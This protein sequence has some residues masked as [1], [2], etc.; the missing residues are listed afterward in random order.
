[1]DKLIRSTVLVGLFLLLSFASKAQGISVSYLIPTDGYL[2]APVSPFSVR[3][4]RLPF[5]RFMGLQGGATLYNFPG[6]PIDDM[7]FEYNEPM[8]GSTFGVIVPAELYVG[9]KFGKV[10]VIASG[11]VFGLFFF[12]DRMIEGNWDRGYADFRGWEVANGNVS[13][14]NK[15][16]YGWLG[17]LEFEV[18]VTRQYS[19]TFGAHYLYGSAASSIS[20]EVTGGTTANGLVTEAIGYL[21]ASSRLQGLEISFGVAF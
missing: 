17:G 12:N 15:G 6:L 11:G 4:L 5:S 14:D 21:D 2:S 8:R 1:M 7:E 9:G 16:G 13:L 3:G 18:P 20:G 10:Q 19:I